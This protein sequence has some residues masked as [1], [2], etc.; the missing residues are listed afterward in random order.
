MIILA[1]V[2][3]PP[4]EAITLV[5]KATGVVFLVGMHA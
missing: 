1:A 4:A 5:G 3:A 2:E